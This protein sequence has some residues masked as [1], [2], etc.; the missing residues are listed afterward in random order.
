M[1]IFGKD[2]YIKFCIT[3]FSWQK[4]AEGEYYGSIQSLKTTLRMSQL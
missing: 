2:P 4:M 1:S 3:M